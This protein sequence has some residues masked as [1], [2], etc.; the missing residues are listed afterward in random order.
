MRQSTE[1]HCSN[2]LHCQNALWCMIVLSSSCVIYVSWKST[3]QMHI[4]IFYSIHFPYLALQQYSSLPTYSSYYFYT[5]TD[6]Q[7]VE[8]VFVAFHIINSICPLM[9]CSSS[10]ERGLLFVQLNHLELYIAKTAVLRVEC[11][12]ILFSLIKIHRKCYDIYM[13][14]V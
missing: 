1:N 8:S 11:M 6:I 2:Q 5:A 14:S 7:C 4:A 12:A 9:E 13:S 10:C 3:S